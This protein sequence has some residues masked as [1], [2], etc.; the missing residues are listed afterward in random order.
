MRE[1]DVKNVTYLAAE[2]ASIGVGST[3]AAKTATELCR[4]GRSYKRL[5]ERLCGGE[6]EWGPHPQAQELIERA[7]KQR[8][9]IGERA[10][11]V[12]RAA[13]ASW[14]VEPTKAFV[15]A[16]EGVCLSV[17]TPSSGLPNNTILR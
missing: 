17:S 9:R 7:K 8:A 2:L 1:P 15:V 6:D 13:L 14:N 12:L 4:L 11:E 10:R 16:S 5:S 3:R